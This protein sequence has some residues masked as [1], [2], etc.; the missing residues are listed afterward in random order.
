MP[1]IGRNSSGTSLEWAEEPE[2]AGPWIVDDLDDLVASLATEFQAPVGLYDPLQRVWR[3]LIGAPA[4]AFPNL[5]TY[6]QVSERNR[7]AICQEPADPARLWLVLP[8][9][10]D[11]SHQ[12]IAVAGFLRDADEVDSALSSDLSNAEESVRWG[13]PCPKPALRAWGQAVADRLQVEAAETETLEVYPPPSLADRLIHRLRI[14]DPPDRFQRMAT[15]EI[16]EAV[17]VEAVAWIPGSRRESVIISG[18][19]EGLRPEAYRQLVLN[20]SKRNLW[21]SDRLKLAGPD[22]VHRIASIAAIDPGSGALVGWLVALNPLD[23]QPFGS[24]VE[25]LR[26]VA[27]L[28][29]TQWANARLF[30]EIKELLFG[31]IRSLTAAIDAKD[32][33][34]SGHSE[35]VARIAVR[36]GEELGLSQQERSDLYLM[37]L[38][39]D[40]GKIGIE[41]Q[42]LKKAGSL[43][44]EE[45]RQIQGHVRIGVRILS[46]LKRFQHLLPGVAAH[47]EHV[48][49]SGYPAGLRGEQI[50]LAARILAVADAF[51]AMSSTR[52]YRRPLTPSQISDVFRVGKG[53]QWDPGV[54]DAL[55]ACRD[56]LE[57]IR[58]KGLGESVLRAIG[59]ALDR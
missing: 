49:G 11:G 12:F 14:S 23:G 44:S 32:P 7:V 48:D 47:H 59:G 22:Q 34:T 19:L 45:Y 6:L 42:V 18:E 46:D 27:S 17:Q 55:F 53:S 1:L 39:H 58:Q 3:R 43:S 56:D 2:V 51:D 15:A 35:R 29:A 38:L 4:T 40:V 52:P 28:I 26:T 8:L 31:V 20:S 16:R 10:L 54:V 37:G 57:M 9:T 5:T 33:Y 21:T 50:P 36:L 30:D 25:Q 13:P 41:D 24:E